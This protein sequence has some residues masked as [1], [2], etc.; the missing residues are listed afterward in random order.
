MKSEIFVPLSSSI[1]SYPFE[2]VP[3][4][5]F[6]WRSSAWDLFPKN[7][8]IWQDWHVQL[9]LNLYCFHS[10][11]TA[12]HLPATYKLHRNVKRRAMWF[13]RNFKEAFTI[14]ITQLLSSIPLRTQ[15]QIWQFSKY[16]EIESAFPSLGKSPKKLNMKYHSRHVF[17]RLAEK[18]SN[19]W[20]HN[21]AGHQLVLPHTLSHILLHWYII[22]NRAP[23]CCYFIILS[24]AL[25]LLKD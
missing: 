8:K 23:A 9:P 25:T 14:Q 17:L 16:F 3:D 19:F 5:H 6:K 10:V 13:W 21:T 22:C 12:V 15:M 20:H 2:N 24:Q 4:V 18:Y 1:K 7:N 11:T